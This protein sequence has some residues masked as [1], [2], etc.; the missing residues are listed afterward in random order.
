MADHLAYCRF[1]F[2]D[3]KT[4]P[5]PLWLEQWVRPT[6]PDAIRIELAPM[7]PDAGRL[8]PVSLTV[9]IRITRLPLT[10]YLEE[11]PLDR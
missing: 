7:A 1:S 5:L 10:N 4:R 9:P 11:L 2:R 8:Q 3:P 6:L